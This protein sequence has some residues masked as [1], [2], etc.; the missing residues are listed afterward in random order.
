[1]S[2]L[3]FII[4]LRASNPPSIAVAA[5]TI[6]SPLKRRLLYRAL[7]LSHKS[8][9]LE[10]SAIPAPRAAKTKIQALFEIFRKSP[11]N[12]ITFNFPSSL[13]DAS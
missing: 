8:T 10:T 5:D 7:S 11:D 12:P 6:A 1:M 13:S 3:R 4:H 9:R 2:S